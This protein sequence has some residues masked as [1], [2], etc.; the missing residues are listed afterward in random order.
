M[1]RIFLAILI[2]GVFLLTL[3]QSYW[4]HQSEKAFN[5]KL[6][7]V[8]LDPNARSDAWT[9]TMDDARTLRLCRAIRLVASG[10]K[11]QIQIGLM[12][13]DICNK[14]GDE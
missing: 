12:L 10:N 5:E 2:I 1:T 8:I 13:P 9:N 3:F 14:T 6:S 11:Y 7:A 4:T